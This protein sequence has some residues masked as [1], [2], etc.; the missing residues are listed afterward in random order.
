MD[1]DLED[2]VIIWLIILNPGIL[3][4]IFQKWLMESQKD[5]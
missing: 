5:K 2:L 1:K 4:N 3:L